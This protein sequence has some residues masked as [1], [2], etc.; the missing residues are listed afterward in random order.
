MH[1]QLTR[2]SGVAE[3]NNS[4]VI[5]T[6]V[7]ES[8]TKK[9]EAVTEAITLSRG[10]KSNV[11]MGLVQTKTFDLELTN[12]VSKITVQNNSGTKE[13]NFDKVN[14][15]KT[16]IIPKDLNSSIVNIEYTIIVKNN[17][18]VDGYAKEIVNYISDGL[19]FNQKLNPDWY[20]GDDGNIYTKAL[21]KQAIAT[22][23]TKKVK[24]ILTK[25]MTEDNTGLIN[26]TAEI[27]EAYNDYG[28]EDINSNPANKLETEND[29]GTANVIISVRTGGIF[30]YTSVLLTTILLG[31]IAVFVT[32][33]KLN[34]I[35]RKEGGV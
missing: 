33:S 5:S 28:L 8:G 4:D 6:K 9:A 22:G 32:I 14:L 18:D 12:T 13:Y 10:T 26:N 29:F 2:K 20:V 27:F 7:A 16:E 11:D 30:I 31:G 24:L 3:S 34:I 25:Q 15:A 23:K 1:Y 19:E 35:K 21:A 17:G